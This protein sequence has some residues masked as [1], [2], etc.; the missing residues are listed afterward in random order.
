MKIIAT[1]NKIQ[2]INRIREHLITGLREAKEYA[3]GNPLPFQIDLYLDLLATG[4]TVDPEREIFPEQIER[5]LAEAAGLIYILR[6]RQMQGNLVLGQLARQAA[7]AR[8]GEGKE[9]EA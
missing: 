9:L 4:A 6:G 7:A 8:Q 3:E 1:E 5:C 2:S